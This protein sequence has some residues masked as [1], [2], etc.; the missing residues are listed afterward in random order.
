[1]NEIE[2][3]DYIH[4]VIKETLEAIKNDGDNISLE[5]GN[6]AL[7]ENNKLENSLEL[8]G[9]LREPYL[10]AIKNKINSGQF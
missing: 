3:I 1:M 6:I 9:D 2:K 8:L 5:L 4:S 7:A 10:I